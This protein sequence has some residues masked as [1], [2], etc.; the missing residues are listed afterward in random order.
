MKLMKRFNTRTWVLLGGLLLALVAL[1]LGIYRVAAGGTDV[2]AAQPSPLHPTFAF[3]DAD[4]ANVLD[5]G[6]PVSTMQ[7]CGQCHDTEY[8]AGHSYHADVGLEQIQAGATVDGQSWDSSSGVFAP[9]VKPNRSVTS[10][11]SQPSLS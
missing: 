9:A 10:L 6:E 4:G 1:G 8:I 7:T 2:P 3:L 11:P 5:S